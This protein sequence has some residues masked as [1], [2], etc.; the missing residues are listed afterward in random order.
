MRRARLYVRKG[1][2]IVPVKGSVKILPAGEQSILLL[3][4]KNAEVVVET[5]RMKV[6]LNP[7][8]KELFWRRIYR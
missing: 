7:R 3:G 5:W 6:V 4:K 2:R 1:T 8:T